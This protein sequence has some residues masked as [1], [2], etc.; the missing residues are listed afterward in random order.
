M[1][2]PPRKEFQPP[3]GRERLVVQ[4]AKKEVKQ[5]MPDPVQLIWVGIAGLA[6][7][8]GD[9]WFNGIDKQFDKVDTH[10]VAMDQKLDSQGNR[11][12]KIETTLQ[13]LVKP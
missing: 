9:H 3:M 1:A 8:L 7:F 11:L 12:T 13:M 5:W 4:P 10:F 2:V 6:C